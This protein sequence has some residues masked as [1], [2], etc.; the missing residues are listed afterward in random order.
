VNKVM[1]FRP[2]LPSKRA[3]VIDTV[4]EPLLPYL[5]SHYAKAPAA[6][7]GFGGLFKSADFVARSIWEKYGTSKKIMSTRWRLC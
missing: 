7:A 5:G 4:K 2:S 6:I 1:S 3:A